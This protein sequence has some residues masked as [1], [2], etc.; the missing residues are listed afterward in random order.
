MGGEK[1]PHGGKGGI[2]FTEDYGVKAQRGRETMAAAKKK[3]D[4]L[5]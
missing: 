2:T 1:R 3:G 4:C 5:P